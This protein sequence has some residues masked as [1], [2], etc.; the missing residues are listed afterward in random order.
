MIMLARTH[1]HIAAAGF[2]AVMIAGCGT[3]ILSREEEIQ[4]GREGS[5][6]LEQRYRLSTNQADINLVRRIGERI[7]S[8]NNLSNWPWTFK[9][10][11]DRTV[12]AV[13]LPGGPIYV[14][15]GLLDATDRNEAEIAGVMAHEIA[16]VEKRHAAK[17][18]SSQVI[19]MG[20][21]SVLLGGDTRTLAQLANMLLQL[22]YSRDDEFDADTN[23]IRYMV[24]SGFDP[25]GLVR[26]FEKLQRLNNEG[27]GN[28]VTNNLR[29]HPLTRDRIERAKQEIS[30]IT[31]AVN[32][33]REALDMIR[34]E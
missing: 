2:A 31:Q 19:A 1:T 25:W 9:V 21:I 23:G 30:R 5:R 34:I 26:F 4:V 13:S 12:N 32:R 28:V 10:I 15:R 24:R 29:T 17:Q 27:Q 14:F 6:G 33:D 20:G 7:V 22:R 11:E 8:Q 3:N 18:Y 16:H